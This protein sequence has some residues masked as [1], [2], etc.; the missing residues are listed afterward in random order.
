MN[1]AHNFENVASFM[2][3]GIN[4]NNKVTVEEIK[5]RIMLGNCVYFSNVKLIRSKLVTWSTKMKVYKTLI[6]PVMTNGSEGMDPK[7]WRRYSFDGV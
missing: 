5:R 7:F 6:L 2:Y 4:S 3:L 1:V